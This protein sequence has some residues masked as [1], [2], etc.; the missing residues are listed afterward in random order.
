MIM[1]KFAR[2]CSLQYTVFVSSEVKSK[3]ELALLSRAQWADTICLFAC[4][5][6]K[7]MY[8]SIEVP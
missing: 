3:T 8:G 4:S 7:E 1:W 6:Y 2:L 5:K